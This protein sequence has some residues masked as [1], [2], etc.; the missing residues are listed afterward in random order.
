MSLDALTVVESTQRIKLSR[1]SR[2]ETWSTVPQR[3]ISKITTLMILLTTSNWPRSTSNN[4]IASPALS[5]LESLES[6]P[7]PEEIETRDTLPSL[8]KTL[9]TTSL[10]DSL[11]Q[12]Q[13]DSSEY[14]DIFY[15]LVILREASSLL[16]IWYSLAN[17][18]NKLL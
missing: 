1:D 13:V 6:D 9:N 18:F 14:F 8:D 10:V 2:W 3:E 5:T 15:Q 12:H 17:Y 7:K 11:F 4:N 16:F